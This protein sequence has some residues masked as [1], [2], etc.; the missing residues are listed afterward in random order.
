MKA[1]EVPEEVPPEPSC[2]V[3]RPVLLSWSQTPQT[4][5]SSHCQSLAFLWTCSVVVVL[6]VLVDGKLYFGMVWRNNYSNLP[7]RDGLLSIEKEICNNG[8]SFIKLLQ[9]IQWREH[10][11]P[12]VTHPIS[13]NLVSSLR[14]V[15]QVSSPSSS[16]PVTM[17]TREVTPVV[18]AG[19]A[20]GWSITT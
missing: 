12:F 15:R 16:Q 6:V 17:L 1:R 11:Q 4:L 9:A 13:R 3:R 7:L 10:L 18:V 8:N 5:G 20:K 19:S 2:W 14:S